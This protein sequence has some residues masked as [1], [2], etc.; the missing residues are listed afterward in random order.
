MNEHR[1]KEDS[2]NC[3]IFCAQHINNG[4]NVLATEGS[5]GLNPSEINEEP[6]A[7]FSRKK[8]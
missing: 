3:Y 6:V 4:K 5:V 7:K 2:H 1:E 8:I